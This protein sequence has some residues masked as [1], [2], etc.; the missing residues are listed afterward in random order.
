VI[1]TPGDLVFADLDGIMVIPRAAEKEVID[2]VLDRIGTENAVR[3][4]LAEG[5]AMSEVWS[6]YRV[7]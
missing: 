6:R 5:K 2:K 3:R 4:E 7:L 1:I